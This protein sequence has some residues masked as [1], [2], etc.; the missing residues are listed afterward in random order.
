[1]K[2]LTLCEF[3]ERSNQIHNH[4][5]DYSKVDFVNTKTKVCI[6]CPIH[7]VFEQ[8]PKN[9]MNGQGC[10]KC[11]KEYAK[12][13]HKNNYNKFILKVNE[14]FG[15]RYSFPYIEDEY[16][17][18]NS[19][20]TVRCNWC[21]NEFKKVADYVFSSITG[22]CFCKESEKDF[23]SYDEINKNV[24][25]GYQIVKYDGLK[26]IKNDKV[27]IMC[28]NCCCKFERN[29]KVVLNKEINCP[30]CLTK[31]N[32]L[33]TIDE[34]K[35]KMDKLFP[36]IEIDYNNY[37]NTST[38]VLCKC[39][40][41]GHIFKRKI[42]TFF[43]GNL[44][45]DPCPKCNQEIITKAK[46]K[47][48]S[49]F[50]EQVN[51]LYGI[52]AYDVL[53]EYESSN[54]KVTVRCNQCNKTFNIEANSFLHGHGCPYHNCNS[55]LM[56][57]EIADFIKNKTDVEVLTN[58][59]KLIDGKELDIYI[60]SLKLAFEFDGIFWH[61]E[62]NK[63]YD[64]HLNKTI[65]CENEGIRLIHIFEDEW[66]NKKH[67]WKSMIS[68]LLG[69]TTRKIFARK[70]II[71]KVS[72]SEALNFLNENHIQ[73]WCPSQIKLAL[74]YNDD[75]VSIMT[76]GK[77][78]HFIGNGKYEYE[79]IRFCNK[80]NTN[81]VGGAS[82]LFSYFIKEY[83]P[84]NIVS[85]SDRRWSVGALYNKLGFTTTHYSKPN[86]FYVIGNERKNRFN[87]RK[88]MLVKKYN[89][90]IDMSEKEFC[91]KQKWYRIYDC[92]TAVHVWNNKQ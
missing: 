24:K 75:L 61:N 32:R 70:C 28:N 25:D 77:S 43:C 86:Y 26:S 39:K 27:T 2:K 21:G 55:S 76:F 56:E 15:N 5:Y 49:F 30:S 12:E 67:I 63:P 78:R 35:N 44:K 58:Y 74:Y 34:I 29:I 51:A 84:T 89:C 88:S 8:T 48:T 46:I 6:I 91:Y 9:H 62:N 59:R 72:S 73:G 17:N 41:C 92:G 4:K 54:K 1:M 23:I 81:V 18:K 64:Y 38:N 42:N 3:V 69:K 66:I 87:Y 65:N 68:N 31:I 36:T 13:C 90:P 50:Q 16:E 19:I 37:V 80:L 52:G 47:T 40:K 11:G 82:K 83:N 10:P 85:Y 14:R 45:G 53:S 79:L 7:G 22:G 60:P 57:K 20:I 71:K 33:K